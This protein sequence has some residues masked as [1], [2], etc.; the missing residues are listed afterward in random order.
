MDTN[1][2]FQNVS[3]MTDREVKVS[4]GEILHP[5][6]ISTLE[7]MGPQEPE[8]YMPIAITSLRIL[9]RYVSNLEK[10]AGKLPQKDLVKRLRGEEVIFPGDKVWW[11]TIAGEK[12]QGCFIEWDNDTAIVQRDDNVVLAV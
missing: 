2:K 9:A 7:V 6:S 3:D 12:Y 5:H 10:E 1:N 11:E 4:A 8:V